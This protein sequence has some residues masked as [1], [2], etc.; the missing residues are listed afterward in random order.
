MSKAVL[1]VVL[2]L[3]G[4]LTVYAVGQVGLMGLFTQ[5]LN[6]AAGQQ[7]FAD[8][9]IALSLFLVWL[10]FDARKTGRAFWPWAL[11]TLALGSF[12]P[13][14]YLLLGKPGRS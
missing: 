7:V 8:L 3:F 9:V 5:N 13:L 10:W 4:A 2:V 14:L 11:A 6:H 1:M 12:G